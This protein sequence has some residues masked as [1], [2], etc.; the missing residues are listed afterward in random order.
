SPQCRG[1]SHPTAAAGTRS[2]APP[3]ATE[4]APPFFEPSVSERPQTLLRSHP[5]GLLPSNLESPSAQS[6]QYCFLAATRCVHPLVLKLGSR[7][8]LNHLKKREIPAFAGM[9]GWVSGTEMLNRYYR[10]SVCPSWRANTIS[11]I[12]SAVMVARKAAIW[13]IVFST[14]VLGCSDSG[15][16]RAIARPCFVMIIV[17]PRSTSMSN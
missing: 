9:T 1:V 2:P 16:N 10:Q 5:D 4:A 8:L 6:R 11:S 17:S 13:F 3:S 14:S 12:D 7:C 15:P